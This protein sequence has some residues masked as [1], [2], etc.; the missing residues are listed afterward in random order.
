MA[1]GNKKLLP[2]LIGSRAIFVGLL[3]QA[4]YRLA[5]AQLRWHISHPS[6]VK[7]VLTCIFRDAD[8]H[9]ALNCSSIFIFYFHLFIYLESVAV[10]GKSGRPLI[11]RFY[12][13]G[14]LLCNFK[15]LAVGQVYGSWRCLAVCN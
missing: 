8:A 14:S 2:H 13:S 12:F 4:F 3:P 9:R 5:E 10:S 15:C 6:S 7:R 11:C 1:Q